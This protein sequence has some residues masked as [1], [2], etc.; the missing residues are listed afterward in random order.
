MY[1]IKLLAGPVCGEC[2]STLESIFS[3]CSHTVSRETISFML[4]FSRALIPLSRTLSLG[5]ITSQ[6][7][8]FWYCELEVRISMWGAH[9]YLVYNIDLSPFYSLTRI[10]VSGFRIHFHPGMIL[11]ILILI[12]A[13][14]RENFYTWDYINGFQIDIALRG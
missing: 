8:V 14:K 4:L 12:I 5:P 13:A 10:L 11:Y 9:T 3:F 2:T 6:S 1:Q 7:Y